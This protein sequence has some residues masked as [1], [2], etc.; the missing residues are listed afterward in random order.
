MRADFDRAP[1]SISIA[2]TPVSTLVGG[3]AVM[4]ASEYVPASMPSAMMPSSIARPPAVV[5]TMAVEAA[6]RFARLV[7]SWPISR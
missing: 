3:L 1:T 6:P 7:G 4:A 2:P 5:T